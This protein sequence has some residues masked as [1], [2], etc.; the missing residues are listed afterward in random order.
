MW[1]VLGLGAPAAEGA[2]AAG[3]EAPAASTAS[4]STAPSRAEAHRPPADEPETCAVGSG[5]GPG[6]PVL[7]SL[8]DGGECGAASLASLQDLR[9][10]MDVVLASLEA[11][12]AHATAREREVEDLH[13]AAAQARGEV[14]RER[15]ELR[16]AIE[17]ERERLR[18]EREALEEEK[19][20]M[21]H[22]SVRRSDVLT[23]NVGGERV[24]Q[25]RRSTLCAVED[26]FLAARFSGR[27][28][29]DLDRD[30][31]GRYFINYS[32][33]LFL[34]LL[35]YLGVKETEDPSKEVPLPEGPANQRHQF[36]AMLKFFGML[37]AVTALD[38]VRVPYE[39]VATA[40][41]GIAMELLPKSSSLLLVALE[42][43]AGRSVSTSSTATVYV[44]QGTLM[45]RLRQ[46][47]AWRQVA[48]GTLR[49]GRKSR[50]EFPEPVALQAGTTSCLYLATN[51]AAGIA[52]GEELRSGDTLA[53][54]DD[55]Q[56]FAG[57][58]SGGAV[59]F[60]GFEGFIYWFAFNGRLEYT[61]VDGV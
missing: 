34:P 13:A 1:A 47:D 41:F 52:F 25:R 61:V 42:T 18:A 7:A 54:N 40:D 6:Q 5:L 43:C 19:A 21:S 22:P 26:S 58:T 8:G 29:Q 32:P 20:R 2:G 39:D 51:H 27:W 14:E 46:R 31:E 9:R 28:E 53:E 44:T 56:A 50:I 17:V 60:A 11:Q 35:D 49:P 24:L 55:L 33:E 59:H 4:A 38:M 23:L 37:P 12:L 48:V 36:Q 57:R 16:T 30:E 45:R 3:G 10:S 15:Q